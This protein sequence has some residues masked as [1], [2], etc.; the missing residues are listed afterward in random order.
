VVLCDEKTAFG[1]RRLDGD[2]SAFEWVQEL[3]SVKEF[4]PYQCRGAA[5]TL[6]GDVGIAPKAVVAVI[7][8]TVIAKGRIGERFVV[9]DGP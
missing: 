7:E 8:R 5:G 6:L 2:G 3:Q 1:F 4:P 9:V